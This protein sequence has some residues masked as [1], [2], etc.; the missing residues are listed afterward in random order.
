MDAGVGR[1][2]GGGLA[3]PHVLE[4]RTYHHPRTVNIGVVIP[5][6]RMGLL[7]SAFVVV[8]VFFR[9]ATGSRGRDDAAGMRMAVVMG[10]RVGVLRVGR[11]VGRVTLGRR[12]RAVMLLVLRGVRRRGGVRRIAP[13]RRG[14]GR[15][16]R[17]RRR[18]RVGT[19]DGAMPPSL[20]GVGRRIPRMGPTIARRARMR[21]SSLPS[22]VVVPPGRRSKS[23]KRI[24][25]TDEQYIRKGERKRERRGE[26][27]S[28]EIKKTH[29]G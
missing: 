22:S 23:D 12:R 4:L 6:Q 3:P 8:V 28:S 13:G 18:T 5:E 15:V 17:L 14:G 11:M 1:G 29:T 19:G 9:D 21:T 16:G 10:R 27:E 20:G 2:G 25:K 7:S 26:R 24:S